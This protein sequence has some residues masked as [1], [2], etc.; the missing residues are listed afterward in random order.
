METVQVHTDDGVLTVPNTPEAMMGVLLAQ[1][2]HHGKIRQH[3]FNQALSNLWGAGYNTKYLP[4]CTHGKGLLHRLFTC[5]NHEFC[6]DI[7]VEKNGK[8]VAVNSKAVVLLW[9]VREAIA[10]KNWVTSGS[11]ICVPAEF[12]QD[13][14][15]SVQEYAA[16]N[17]IRIIKVTGLVD[18]V[19]EMLDS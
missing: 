18:T 11:V 16:D 3:T 9:A 17:D 4:Q 14:P 1:S 2:K 5:R 15:C 13:V 6:P 19:R 12:A 10:N 7:R 8:S